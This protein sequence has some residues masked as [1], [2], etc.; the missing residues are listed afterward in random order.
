MNKIDNWF[1]FALI[2]LFFAVSAVELEPNK[3]VGNI[4]A[5]C[6]VG[7]LSVIMVTWNLADA[8]NYVFNVVFYGL[9][10]IIGILGLIKVI[11][12]HFSL[13]STMIV[14][15]F[16]EVLIILSMIL[17]STGTIGQVSIYFI[18]AISFLVI[19]LISIFLF[20]Y[21]EIPKYLYYGFL[22]SSIV[23]SLLLLF[24]DKV[25]DWFAFALV[26][27]FFAVSAVEIEPNK[28]VGS[29]VA[30]C[31]VGALSI[32]MVT[33]SLAEV[34]NYIYNVV[35]YGLFIIIGVLGLIKTIKEHFTL[36]GTLISFGFAEV[37]IILSMILQSTSTAGQISIY[38]IMANSFL[39]ISLFAIFLVKFLEVSQ[40]LYLGFIG[41]SL[42]NSLLLLFMAKVSSWYAFAMLI[43]FF[44][45][46]AIELEPNIG[47]NQIIGKCVVGALSIIMVAVNFGDPNG[48]I[49]NGV[50]F[51]LFFI[52]GFI[53]LL[54]VLKKYFNQYGTFISIGLAEVHAI[55]LLVL[56]TPL[57]NLQ[58]TFYF[59][60]A[61]SFNFIAMI[62]IVFKNVFM[63]SDVLL[64]GW[65]IIASI[66]A[67][68][69]GLSSK[70]SP[71]F[72]FVSILLLFVLVALNNLP[73]FGQ[74]IDYWRITSL[75]T[76]LLALVVVAIFVFTDSLEFFKHDILVIFLLYALINIPIFINWKKEEVAV[77]G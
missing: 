75:V 12:K 66:N 64:Y 17:Q 36:P 4:L 16:A 9:F 28:G 19:S 65:V 68:I 10:L 7:I 26:I 11:R 58:I 48:F 41:A 59:I 70:I 15:G 31:S 77:L 76:S 35:F 20:K 21:L 2:L 42:V 23:N 27:L 1:A 25:N 13:A 74:R 30:K 14:F 62:S 55:L 37:L 5:K 38:F 45:I 29:I 52:I 50:F 72:S 22:G 69:M 47:R 51:G 46:T 49:F 53:G 71:W 24:M 44:A 43:L 61:V 60:I 54:N 39:V 8:N 40:Y 3:G 32:I 73:L 18:M 34:H 6:S 63:R 33:T 67:T 57:N 56:M